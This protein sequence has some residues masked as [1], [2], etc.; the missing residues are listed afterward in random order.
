MCKLAAYARS[1]QKKT[2]FIFCNDCSCMQKLIPQE[3]F[4]VCTA[5]GTFLN[6][7]NGFDTTFFKHYVEQEGVKQIILVGHYPCKVLDFLLQDGTD[8]PH[9]A[10]AKQYMRQLKQSF[11]ALTFDATLNWEKFIH[12]HIATQVQNLSRFSFFRKRTGEAAISIKGIVIE[13]NNSLE[14]VETDHLEA[15]LLPINLN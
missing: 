8:S 4:I 10:D 5:L 6:A 2:L 14:V 15:I 11:E 12:Y 7:Q 9:W 3:N 1:Q 13:E